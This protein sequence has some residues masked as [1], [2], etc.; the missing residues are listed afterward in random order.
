MSY[1]RW[2]ASDNG[3]APAIDRIAK[4]IV[5]CDWHYERRDDYPSLPLFQKKG[6]RVWPASWRDLEATQAFIADAGRHDNE[7]MVGHLFTAWRDPD[8]VLSAV[9][10]QGNPR[11]QP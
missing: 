1:G 5:L 4:D 7:R 9:L 11:E 10:G 2:E 3:S 8:R 6:F